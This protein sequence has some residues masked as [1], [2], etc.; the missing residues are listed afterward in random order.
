MG[1]AANEIL[2][3]LKENLELFQMTENQ[4]SQY[5]VAY[6][7]YIDSIVYHNVLSTVGCR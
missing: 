5:W 2:R 6:V 1:A 4:D 7:N 3:L